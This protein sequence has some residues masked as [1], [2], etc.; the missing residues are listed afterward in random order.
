MLREAA[1]QSRSAPQPGSAIPAAPAAPTALNGTGTVAS[2]GYNAMGQLGNGT[3]IDAKTPAQVSGLTSSTAIASGLYTGYAVKSDGTAW[4]WGYNTYGG[5]GDGTTTDRSTPV[6]VGTLTNVIAVAGGSFTGYALKSDGTVWA[7]GNGYDG[8]L[9]NGGTADSHTPVRVGSLT[10]VTAIAGSGGNGYALKSDGTV[11]SWG[12]NSSGQIGDG[13]TTTRLA[14]VQVKNLPGVSAIAAA[15]GSETAYAV[16]SDGTVWSWGDNAS[17]Q[18]GNGSTAANTSTAVQVKNFTGATAIAGGLSDGYALKSD[19]T[20]WSWGDGS[21]GQLGNGGTTQSAVAVQVSGLTGIA[22]IAA[23]GHSAY[24]TRADGTARSWGSNSNGQLGNGTTTNAKTPVVVSTLTSVIAVAANYNSAYALAGGTIPAAGAVPPRQLP[25]DGN[26]CLPCPL[27]QSGTGSGG[28]PVDTSSGAFHERYTD[29][30]VAGRGPGLV[31][32]RSYNSVM[33]ADDGP[34]GYGWHTGYGA[35]LIT[36]ATTGAITVSQENGAEVVF[37]NSSGTYTAPARVQATL[38]KN[39]DGT[40]T[41]TRHATQI[42]RFDSAGHLTAIA[43]LNGEKT[44]L[45][46]AGALLSKVTD[47]AGRALTVTYTG[48]HISKVSDPLGNAYTYAYDSAGNLTTVTAPDG[49]VTTFG[50]DSAHRVTSVLD[51]AQQSATTKHPTTNVYDAKSRV[52]TQTDALGRVTTFVYTG[53]PYSSAGGT[54]VVLDPAGHQ[55]A[56]IYQYGIRV[57]NVRGF[58]TAAAVTT[59]YTYDKTTLAPTE[60]TRTTA[61]DPN[62]HRTTATYDTKGNPTAQVDGLGR[63]VDTTY[64]AFNEP[65]TKTEPNPSSVGPARITTTYAYDSKG[66]LVSK[67]RPLYTSATASTNQT[68]TYRHDASTHPGDVTGAVDPLGKITTTTYDSAGNVATVTTPQGR[69]TTHT[70]DADGHRITTIAPQGAVSG[71]DPAAYTTTFGYDTNGRP[72]STSVAAPGGPLVTSQA[73]DLDGRL[74]SSTDPLGRVSHNTYDLAGEL[75]TATQPDGSTRQTTYWPDGTVKTRVDGLGKITSYGADTLGR[76]ASVTDPLNRVTTYTYDAADAV[77]ITTDPQNQVTT[78]VYD[79]AGQLLTTTYSDGVTPKVT[80]TYNAGGLAATIVD[81]SG[82]TT[83]AYDSLGRLTSQSVAGQT[84]GYGY[85]PAGRVT[86]LTYPNGK[87]VT[88]T[89]DGDGSLTGVSDWLGGASTFGYDGGGR[90]AT[91]TVPNGITTTIGHDAPG[92]TTGITLANGG[93]TLGSLTDTWDTAGQLSSETSAGLGADRAFGYDTDGRLTTDTDTAYAYDS[94]GQLTSNAGTTQA[95]DAAGQLTGAYTFDQRGNRTVAG[96][97]A[98]SYDQ[99][100]RLTSYTADATAAV[101]G[102]NG[103]GLRT[104]KKV[105]TTTST[106]AYDTVEGLPLLLADGTNFYLYGPGGTPI[107]QIGATSGTPTYL[108]ADQLGSV[109]VLTAADGTVANTATYTAYGVRTFGTAGG[110]T[111]PFGFAG[112]YTDAESGLLYLRARYYDPATGQ[113]LTRD[114]ALPLSGSVYGYADG[115][116]IGRK[117][118]SGLWTGGICFT[119]HLG[120]LVFWSGQVCIQIDGH[121]DLGVTGTMAGGGSTPGLGAGVGLQ[122]SNA[123]QIKDLNGLFCTA[124]FSAGAPYF[125]GADFSWGTDSQGRPV[126]V[127]ELSGGVGAE[128]LPFPAEVHGGVSDTWSASFSIPKVWNWLTSLFD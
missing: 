40:Y 122:G 82:T 8:E 71:A 84:V 45:T 127:G 4:A 11:W 106:F 35:R 77:L 73:Y 68:V 59:N 42:L 112:Q 38:V 69:T 98:Y 96:T 49:G 101:Y 37:T 43:D 47:S 5:L 55:T 2:W 18:L 114:P 92:R 93:T 86:T 120:G 28:D 124:G 74:T 58:G 36:N 23:G 119:S 115:D 17:G 34:L 52:T 32:A 54:T 123:D 75:I 91:T 99:A 85:D 88:R 6:R 117:D 13:T 30:S 126:Y 53:D 61:G 64:N 25:G 128:G 3:T 7:W 48:T 76:V 121:G 104:T 1:D 56:D 79:A 50:Y 12:I 94:A 16:K 109:R 103:D 31:W 105:G 46:Y 83:S 62:A 67:S 116:P 118:P 78:N 66:N 108:H 39:A 44:A 97:T 19:G 22:A 9:G 80:R 72:T 14:P 111:T 70:Y 33:A 90:L 60:T 102:Y 20:V 27:V 15:S 81:G 89:Y 125:G 29:L 24:A 65:L 41:F 26:P 107:E 110:T 10:G 51:P 100:N 57:S 113:F 63:E 95:Y 21:Y 87:N